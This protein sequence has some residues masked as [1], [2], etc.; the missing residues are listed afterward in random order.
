MAIIRAD[1]ANAKMIDHWNGEGGRSWVSRQQSQER[2]NAIT[3]ALFARAAVQPGERVIDIGCGTG[4]STADLLRLVGAEGRILG[5]DVSE[6]MLQR[7]R[8]RL[9]S[10]PRLTLV[11]A[12][13]TVYPFPEQSFDLV[14]S[15]M[16]VMFF[17]EPEKSF[18]NIRR[19]LRRG[20]RLVFAC[21]RTLDENPWQAV[22]VRAIRSVVPAQSRP[23]PEAP[24][25]FSLGA[26][27]RLRRIL[28]QA[29][30]EAIV[31]EPV[32]TERDLAQGG[33]LDDAV[34]A[35]ICAGPA[36]PLLR[37]QPAEIVSAATEA[38]RRA[39]APLLRDGRIPLAAAAWIVSARNP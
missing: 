10:D 9:G 32:D 7:A 19:G 12:D 33:G 15:R 29:G 27:A 21:W 6:P 31:L 5:V 23:D 3:D 2:F 38:V 14:L 22:P 11:Q 24:G 36:R 26:E 13:A 20:G 4:V 37:D 30:F 28:S 18:A 17:A 34:K 39:L 25:G 1:A 8:E 35:A 16:G